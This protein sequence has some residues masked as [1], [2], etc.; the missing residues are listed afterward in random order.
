MTDFERE[1]LE[2]LIDHLKLEE[3]EVDEIDAGISLFNEGLELDSIDIIEIEVLAKKEYGIDILTSERT[4]EVFGTLGTLA[5]FIAANR[6]R[7]S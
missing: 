6:D 3:I 2:K 7:D 5:A 4:P 1:L